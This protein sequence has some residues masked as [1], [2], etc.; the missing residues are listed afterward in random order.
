MT[1]VNVLIDDTPDAV[2][3]SC[4]DAE[5]R[6]VAHVALEALM[7]DG[8]LHPQRIEAAYAEALS[9]A[10]ERALAAGHPAAEHARVAP[11]HQDLERTMAR[12]RMRTSR[13]QNGPAPL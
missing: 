8:R 9:A 2:M 12:L 13:A 4:F 10:E 3:L 1:G 5:R 6:E 7:A 11:R